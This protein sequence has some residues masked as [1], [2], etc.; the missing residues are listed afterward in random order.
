MKPKIVPSTKLTYLHVTEKM[1]EAVFPGV[2]NNLKKNEK[3]N[4]LKKAFNKKVLTFGDIWTKY[5]GPHYRR[6]RK[7]LEASREDTDEGDNTQNQI[8]E[9]MDRFN[10]KK[11]RQNSLTASESESFNEDAGTSEA[12][13]EKSTT[14]ADVFSIPEDVEEIHPSRSSQN[15]SIKKTP[16]KIIEIESERLI[17]DDVRSSNTYIEKDIRSEDKQSKKRRFDR[18]FEDEYRE[19]ME[20]SAKQQKIDSDF[21]ATLFPSIE[22]K[23]PTDPKDKEIETRLKMFDKAVSDPL[24]IRCRNLLSRG[25]REEIREQ[26]LLTKHIKAQPNEMGKDTEREKLR[27]SMIAKTAIIALSRIEDILDTVSSG[28]SSAQSESQIEDMLREVHSRLAND[29]RIMADRVIYTQRKANKIRAR[30]EIDQAMKEISFESQPHNISQGFQ[31]NQSMRGSY[32]GRRFRTSFN[33]SVIHRSPF[34]P[35]RNRTQYFRHRRPRPPFRPAYS[36]RNR[37]NLRMNSR[38]PRWPRSRYNHQKQT[39]NQRNPNF[40]STLP[41]NH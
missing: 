29:I 16:E 14:A 28:Q 35:R 18:L 5:K 9:F 27:S 23:D 25:E 13:R 41:K 3:F 36:N 6:Y 11:S 26:S 7:Y 1:Y 19:L 20:Y 30:L 33:A 21:S 37:G 32:S 22:K 12:C 2:S 38:V 34:P 4:Q 10:N 40:Q 8:E 15:N 31:N 17:P 39:F 24:T